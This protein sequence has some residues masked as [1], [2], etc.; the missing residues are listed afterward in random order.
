LIIFVIYFLS[1]ILKAARVH[2][3]IN[4]LKAILSGLILIYAS[5]CDSKIE[6]DPTETGQAFY[7]LS[8]GDYREYKI[9]QIK[10]S[11][12]N[13]P[14]TIRYLLK[15]QVGDSFINQTGGITYTLNRYKRSNDTVAWVIDSVWTVI[16]SE[17]NVVVNE[18]NI[19]FA[20]L[21]FPVLDQKQWDGNAFNTLEEELYLYEH[22]YQPIN[23]ENIDFNSTITVIH[24]FNQD[25]IVMKDIRNEI[26]AENVGLIYKESIILHYCT[27]NECLGKQII[28]QGVDF[29]QELIG[30]GN[31]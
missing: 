28:E 7:P 17:T 8:T 11:I 5:G 22:T 23:L 24:E 2:P 26:Y 9:E 13:T 1:N 6:I 25:S 10:Y 15:E 29:K 3:L 12:L 20:K 14:D 27:E 19:P 4:N 30:Y 18:N 16:K 31:E 21:V